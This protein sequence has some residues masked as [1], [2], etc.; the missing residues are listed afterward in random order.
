M[1]NYNNNYYPN[2][3]NPYS[4]YNNYQQPN[5]YQ[6]QPQPQVQQQ[7]YL[8]LTYVK[9]LQEAKDFIVSANQAIF[10]KDDTNGILY[11][12]K[13]DSVGKSYITPYRLTEIS[14][15]DIGK[16]PMQ[17]QKIDFVTKDDLKQLET[18]IID[19]IDTLLQKGE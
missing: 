2:Y 6:Q 3:L 8:P 17:E 9:S 15:E 1:N 16:Q 14:F 11:E 13:A 18:S 7:V 10:L 12:K 4:M 19:K 5:Y